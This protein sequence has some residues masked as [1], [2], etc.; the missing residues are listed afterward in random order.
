LPTSQPNRHTIAHTQKA[1]DNSVFRRGI[2]TFL[3]S[4]GSLGG[5][6]PDDARQQREE[7]RRRQT[8]S[9]VL[10]QHFSS[11]CS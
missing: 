2:D 7:L 8:V 5:A 1:Q 10:V 4:L 11:R 9:W 6:L 3:Q